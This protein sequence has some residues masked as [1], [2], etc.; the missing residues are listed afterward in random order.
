MSEPTATDTDP[1][2]AAEQRAKDLVG[3]VISQRYRIDTLIAMGGMGAVYKGYHLLLKK[4]VAIK[5]LHPETENLPELVARFERE[6]I[7]GAHVAHPNVASATDFGQLEDG[8][9]FLVLELVSGKTLDAAIKQGPMPPARA[10]HIAKQIASGL[11]AVH[12]MDIVHRDLKPRNVML[13]E[14]QNDLAKIIDF[15]LAKVSVDRVVRSRRADSVGGGGGAPSAKRPRLDSIG[16]SKPRLTGVGVIFGT[17]AYLAP[18][19]ALGMEGVDARADLYALGIILYEML[20]GKRPFE[21]ADDATLFALQRFHAPP[22]IAARAPGV[23]VPAALEAIAMRLLEKQPAARYATAAHVVAALDALGDAI[24]AAPASSTDSKP[25]ARALDPASGPEPR[26]PKDPSERAA[27]RLP[28]ALGVL[29]L[30]FAAALWL[31]RGS[32]PAE[33]STT[34]ASS[35]PVASAPAPTTSAEPASSAAPTAEPTASA[36]AEAPAP[37]AGDGADPAVPAALLLRAL[38]VRDWNG[39]EAAFFDLI[40]RDPR[41]L[42]GAEMA[43]AARDLA[44]TLEREHRGDRIFEALTDK[45]GTDGLDVLYDLVASKGRSS[46]AVRAA[47]ALRRKEVIERASPEMRIAFE[48]REAPCVDK[49]ALLDRAVKEGDARALI[50]LENQGLACFRKNNKAV[51]EAMKELRARLSRK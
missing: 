14:G 9:Y 6:A 17:I 26:A 10:V 2:R 15:G 20:S 33:S 27:W 12:A 44:A 25:S 21:A 48:L 24:Q 31:L 11:A 45:V 47:E 39:G 1:D 42:H 38:R 19:A 13:V 40:S 8:S 46:A 22:S 4:R 34:S 36:S 51:L 37:P 50:V 35:A 32:P 28:V 49:L 29:V 5:I 41:A 30:A 3:Q 7:A 23:E 43:V 18:E 16:D